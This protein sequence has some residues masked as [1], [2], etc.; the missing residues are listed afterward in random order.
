MM[1]IDITPEALS[2]IQIRK[3]YLTESFGEGKA[4]QIIKS[5]MDNIEKL[6]LFPNTG[7]DILERWGV[8]SDYRC[9]IIRRNYVFYRE[10]GNAIKIIRV[11]DERQNFMKILFGV[12]GIS[13][14]EYWDD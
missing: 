5:V 8:E 9:L 14:D 10:E 13:D 11:L 12:S 3:A 1:Y 7:I 2:D 4:K 6:A